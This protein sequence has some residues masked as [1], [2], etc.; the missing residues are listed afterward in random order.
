MEYMARARAKVGKPTQL[1][2]LWRHYRRSSRISSDIT[3]IKRM[4]G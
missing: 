1:L 3:H 2:R 4:K